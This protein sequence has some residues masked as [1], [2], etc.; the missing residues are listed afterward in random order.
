METQQSFPGEVPAVWK[1][2][3]TTKFSLGWKKFFN[4]NLLTFVCGPCNSHTFLVRLP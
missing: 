2:I 4:S 1:R 3:E